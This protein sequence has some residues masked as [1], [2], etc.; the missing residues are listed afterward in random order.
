MKPEYVPANSGNENNR[1]IMTVENPGEQ[2]LLTILRD[3]ALRQDKAVV[4]VLDGAEWVNKKIPGM[5]ANPVTRLSFHLEYRNGKPFVPKVGQ[6]VDPAK[7]VAEISTST[8]NRIKE[9]ENVRVQENDGKTVV[10]VK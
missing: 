3:L 1:Y 10:E 9:A 8:L 5:P 4:L 2:K 7:H 6:N